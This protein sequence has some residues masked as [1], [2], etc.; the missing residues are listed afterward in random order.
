MVTI[1]DV[2]TNEIIVREMNDEEYTDWQARV[3]EGEAEKTAEAKAKTDR[4]ALLARLGITEQ[5]AALLLG[6]TN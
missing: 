5:E 6:G 1:H 3:A 2:S 4:T